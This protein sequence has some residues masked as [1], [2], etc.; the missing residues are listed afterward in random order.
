MKKKKVS[1]NLIIVLN[2]K[3]PLGIINKKNKDE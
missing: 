1:K 3:L 2:I